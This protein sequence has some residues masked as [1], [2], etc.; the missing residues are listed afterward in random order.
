MDIAPGAETFSQNT[1]IHTSKDP[2]EHLHFPK[3]RHEHPPVINVNEEVEEQMTRGQKIADAVAST[4]GS[5][6]FIII[7][8]TILL[9]WL[10][11]NS[12]A[13]AFRWDPYP[14]ILLNLALSFQAAYSAPFV[15]MSQNRQAEKDRI[16]AQSD[17]QTDCKGEEEIR[18]IMEHLDHQDTLILQ[19]L[20]QMVE[21]RSELLGHLSRLDPEL[22]RQLGS[23][24]QQI[25]IEHL[26][27][28]D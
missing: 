3:F 16:T 20:N 19:V 6:R 2:R 26:Q 4:V 8:S 28:T 12:I 22:A 9:M 14:F 5:W 13:W 27:E 11:L 17:Y 25:T 24:M 10:I 15:M 18:H 7:Q 1:Q 21:Q 23:E